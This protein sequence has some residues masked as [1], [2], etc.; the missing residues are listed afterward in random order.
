MISA[1]KSVSA[2]IERKYGRAPHTPNIS[3]KKILIGKI[4][5]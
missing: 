5:G 2:Q 1:N 4:G 3:S